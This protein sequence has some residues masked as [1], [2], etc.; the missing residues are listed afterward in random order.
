MKTILATVLLVLLGAVPAHPAREQVVNLGTLAPEGSA[1]HNVLRDMAEE[2]KTAA[3]GKVR[4]RIYPG[5]VAGDEPFMVRKMRNNQLQAA[6][7]TGVGLAEIAPE[8]MALQLP[9]LIQS[10][11]EL[12]YVLARMAPKLEA[13]LHAKGY[14][15][16]NWG[17]AGWVTFFAQRPVVTVDDLRKVKLFVWASSTGEVEVWKDAGITAVPLEATEIHPALATGLVNA[18]STTPL[19]A[20]SFQWF[21]SAK[22]MTGMKW[23]PLIGA[24]VMRNDAWEKIP[25]ELK[26]ALRAAARSSGER[27]KKETRQLGDEAVKIMQQHGL[28]VH[29]VPAAALADWERQARAAYPAIMGKTIPPAMRDEVERLRNE[30]RAARKPGP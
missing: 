30:Y 27:L 25:E 8:V 29:P 17:D 12:D 23:A 26:P 22:H 1:W 13:I 15:V 24:T 20:L 11:E 21:G 9:M 7:L 3:A 6:A 14:T 18:F 2:W 4:F 28:V 5:G 16:L 10:Y 19:A